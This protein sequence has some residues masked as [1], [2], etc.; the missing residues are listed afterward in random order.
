MG[1]I[2]LRTGKAIGKT[3]LSISLAFSLS[4]AMVSM[5]EHGY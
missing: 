4:A 5:V 2:A 3:R 1:G